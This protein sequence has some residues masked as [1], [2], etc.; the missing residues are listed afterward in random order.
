MVEKRKKKR[1]LFDV[2]NTSEITHR[3][4]KMSD[5]ERIHSL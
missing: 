5:K 3:D 1:F 4:M 2:L